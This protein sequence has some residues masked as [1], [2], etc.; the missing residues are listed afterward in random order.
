MKRST[1][2]TCGLV[3]AIGTC[4]FI[5]SVLSH[6]INDGGQDVSAKGNQAKRDRLERKFVELSAKRAKSMTL[7]ELQQAVSSSIMI[8]E[9][10]VHDM[11]PVV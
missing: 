1:I 8:W 10:G 4:V 3:L 5:P 7:P 11:A 2:V 9:W 6:Q